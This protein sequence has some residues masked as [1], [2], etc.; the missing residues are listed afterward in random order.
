MG[1]TSLEEANHS[2]EHQRNADS[3]YLEAAGTAGSCCGRGSS[4]NSSSVESLG[5]V[6]EGGKVTTGRFVRVNG[7]I[8]TA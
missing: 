2:S 1:D 4:S 8:S 6:L 5:N 7:T 3:S